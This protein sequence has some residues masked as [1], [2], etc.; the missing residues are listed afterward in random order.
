MTKKNKLRKQTSWDSWRDQ[1]IEPDDFDNEPTEGF[2]LNKHAGG[3]GNSY[4]HWDVRK[5]YIRV[6]DPRGFEFEITVSNLLYILENTSSIKGKGLEGRFVYGWDGKE[7]VLIPV[8]TPEYQDMKNISTLINNSTYI[9]SKDLILGATYIDKNNEQYIYM[10][11][12]DKYSY[13]YSYCQD[14]S[15]FIYDIKKRQY[16]FFPVKQMSEINRR[17]VLFSNTYIST[18]I[19]NSISKKFIQ[20]VDN[21]CNTEYNKIYN[22]LTTDNEF[23]P[24]DKSKTKIHYFTLEEFV[25]IAKYDCWLTMLTDKYKN[26]IYVRKHGD[27]YYIMLCEPCSSG[28]YINITEDKEIS[29]TTRENVKLYSASYIYNMLHPFVYIDFLQNGCLSGISWRIPQNV[30]E[31]IYEKHKGDYDYEC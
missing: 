18:L 19:L 4:S 26:S 3:V 16:W 14:K 10:G 27:L 29:I 2:V 22:F 8:D 6:Y 25:D 15:R 28:S 1:N 12:F 13:P 5:S 7:L 30:K 23:C 20:C 31:S 17:G 24:L 9:K 21:Q 11:R